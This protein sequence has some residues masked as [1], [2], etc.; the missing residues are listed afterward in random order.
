MRIVVHS[1]LDDP[2]RFGVMCHELAHVL[3]GHLGNDDDR[4]WPNRWALDLGSIEVEAE[5]AAFIATWRLGLRG[6][7]AR[8]VSRYMPAG[9]VPQGISARPHREGRRTAA[10]D[11]Y[12]ETAGAQSA[13]QASAE[14]RAGDRVRLSVT[15]CM[16]EHDAWVH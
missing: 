5:A 15:R 16:E 3:L 12:R 13:E 2:S 14:G 9:E 10:A 4:W 1:G 8:Y 11:G 7:S 6:S